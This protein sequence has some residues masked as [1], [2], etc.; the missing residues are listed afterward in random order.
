MQLQTAAGCMIDCMTDESVDRN[1]AV[2]LAKL[3]AALLG[4]AMRE[5]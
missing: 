1:R 3:H 2:S 4:Q 5:P